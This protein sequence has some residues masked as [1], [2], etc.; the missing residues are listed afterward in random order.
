MHVQTDN[1]EDIA[2]AVIRLAM[3]SVTKICIVPIQ[4][5]LKKDGSAR[6]NKPATLGD[7]WK[8]RMRREELTGEV[9]EKIRR[10][11]WLYGR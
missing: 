9:V 4:E 11:T 7:N 5:F 8:W 3:S 2:E 6:I 10:M 1:D